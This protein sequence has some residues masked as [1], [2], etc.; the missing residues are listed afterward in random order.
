MTN[1][2][3]GMIFFPVIC[4]VGIF[5]SYEDFKI[6]KIK[7]KW[8][9]VGL[10]YSS[11]IYLVSWALV[12]SGNCPE[13]SFLRGVTS[14]LLWN[15]D[16]WLINLAISACVAFAMWHFNL[17]GAGDA[18]LFICYASLIPMS[19]YT[20]IYFHYYFASF[21]M[22]LAIFIP[23]TIPLVMKSALYFLKKID[24]TAIRETGKRIISMVNKETMKVASGLLV[25]FLSFRALSVQFNDFLGRFFSD[26]YLTILISLLVFNRLS[27][28][29]KKYTAATVLLVLLLLAYY[30]AAPS[31]TF[32]ADIT[33][34]S[35]QSALFLL[36]FPLYRIVVNFYSSRSDHGS[37]S[38]AIWMFLGA[39][40]VWVYP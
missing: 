22:L 6:S 34:A 27:R 35:M 13:G 33:R 40:I 39:L 4:L 10:L 16:K 37:S 31:A 30:L 5:T 32:L 7:N 29:L 18:K 38:F 24:A 19:Q 9:M 25:L 1:I 36:L 2:I 15:F 11:V 20:R 26:P 28:F 21:L 14:G 17:W 8:V 23:A 3:N 12:I